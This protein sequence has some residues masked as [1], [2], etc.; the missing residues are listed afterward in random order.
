[1]SIGIAVQLSDLDA[2]FA[3]LNGYTPAANT[4]ITYGPSHLDIASRYAPADVGTP[5]GAI[6]LTFGASRTDVGN[7]FAAINTATFT[8]TLPQFP[9]SFTSTPQNG[10]M[11]VTLNDPPPGPY[12][13]NWTYTIFAP[14]TFTINSGQGTNTINWTA[15]GVSKE[16]GSITVSCAVTAS[17][18]AYAAGNTRMRF[19]VP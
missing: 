6:G 14:A 13:Y 17:G 4:G 12:T 19:N 18:G 15:T 1:M 16:P 11:T 7:Y 5:Y 10:S 9:N 2:L 3:P 8:A